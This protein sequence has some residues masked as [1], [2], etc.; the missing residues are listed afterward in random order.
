MKWDKS[1]VTEFVDAGQLIISH[2]IFK[3]FSQIPY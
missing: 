3:N 2:E 1:S